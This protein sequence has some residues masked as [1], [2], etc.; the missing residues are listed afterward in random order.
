ML[1]KRIIE[2]GIPSNE[3][4]TERPVEVHPDMDSKTES[5]A[6]IPLMKYGYAVRRGIRIH[7]SA[8][9]AKISP[10]FSSE[11]S[12][13]FVKIFIAK[14]QWA[15]FL[16]IK[17]NIEVRPATA[18]LKTPGTNTGIEGAIIIATTRAIDSRLDSSK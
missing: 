15:S 6:D 1:L 4:I 10:N 14:F 12:G 11:S 5:C 16:K 7:E 9:T 17:L 3:V 18:H 2:F 13:R 8:V